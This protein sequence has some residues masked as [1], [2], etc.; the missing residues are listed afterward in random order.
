[1][2]T[3]NATISKET[4]QSLVLLYLIGQFPEGIFSSFRLQKVLYFATRSAE[5]KPFTFHHTQYGQYSRD[6][7]ALL[8]LMLESDILKRQELNEAVGGA[9]WQVGD[10]IDRED[11]EHFVKQGF[12]PLAHL[13]R[14][15]AQKYSF[16]KQTQLDQLA[17]DDPIL[18]ERGP[19][20]VL[21]EENLPGR[22][23]LAVDE[24]AAEDMDMVLRPHAVHFLTREIAN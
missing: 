18:Q 5:L 4:F 6:A 12:A 14:Q 24:D 16:L 3:Q 19:G 20:S 15:S 9:R 17:R 1:M 22:V 21:L 23:A 7:A 2:D 13:V 8:T 10:A 11:I